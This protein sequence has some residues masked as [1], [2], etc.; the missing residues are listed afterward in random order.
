ML[1]AYACSTITVICSNLKASALSPIS[2][3][4][5][6]SVDLETMVSRLEFIFSRSWSRVLKKGLDNNTAAD[7]SSY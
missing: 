5:A 3:I 7:T 1:G 2:R 4:D 6:A